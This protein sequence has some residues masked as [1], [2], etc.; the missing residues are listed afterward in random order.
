MRLRALAFVCWRLRARVRARLGAGQ[1]NIHQEASGQTVAALAVECGN[2][3]VFEELQRHGASA[4]HPSVI[5]AC[6]V[7]RCL[8]RLGQC[9][10]EEARAPTLTED[11]LRRMFDLTCEAG[12]V[13]CAQV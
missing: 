8:Q 12:H 13:D 9:L 4:S 3:R 2:W 11:G 5:Q 6:A 7:N 10:A 1:I